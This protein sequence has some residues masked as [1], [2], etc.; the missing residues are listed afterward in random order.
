[1]KFSLPVRNLHRFNTREQL[2]NAKNDIKIE[3]YSVKLK[4]PDQIYG[5]TQYEEDKNQKS[6]SDSDTDWKRSKNSL[7]SSSDSSSNT[8][9]S[10]VGCKMP[11]RTKKTKTVESVNSSEVS[12]IEND[13][14]VTYTNVQGIKFLNIVETVLKIPMTGRITHN[15]N[16]ADM[17]KYLKEIVPIK[18]FSIKESVFPLLQRL[19]EIDDKIPLTEKECWSIMLTSKILLEIDEI[20]GEELA[21]VLGRAFKYIL[22]RK[23]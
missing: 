17:S 9:E 21:H 10:S 23:S 16:I 19:H 1:M 14:K 4:I 11:V 15:F 13:H 22:L 2:P 3:K 6:R 18:S 7:K 8:S 20:S 12:D 5:E